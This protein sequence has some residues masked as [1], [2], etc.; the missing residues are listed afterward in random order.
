MFIPGSEDARAVAWSAD[1]VMLAAGC[2]GPLIRI[3]NVA[4]LHEPVT[5]RG[6]QGTVES[7]AWSPQAGS[8]VLASSDMNGDVRLWDM[9]A[10]SRSSRSLSGHR[11]LVR[12]LAWSP[13]G[14][15]LA[16]GS[17]DLTIRLWDPR[18]CE[19]EL[20]LGGS[21]LSDVER[22]KRKLK[23]ETE[24][25][26][27]SFHGASPGQDGHQDYITALA[28][29]GDG[30]TLASG[31]Y[32]MTVRLWRPD[33]GVSER[34]VLPFDE[35]IFALAWP[36]VPGMLT[37]G[38]EYGRISLWE[39]GEEAMAREFNC[40]HPEVSDIA[41]APGGTMMAIGSYVQ[42]AITLW[43]ATGTPRGSLAGNPGGVHALAWS[44]DGRLAS[45]GQ[46]GVRLWDGFT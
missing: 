25:Q 24:S 12:A 31:S 42:D 19:L 41:W 7:V 5:L 44:S 30:T 22:L 20:S 15:L 11:D 3:W 16:S 8:Y 13:D 33:E 18:S 36:P 39:P 17:D 26:V 38:E 29:S 27:I 28:W 6:H 1:G 34:A 14:S 37:V 40:G 45:A 21:P 2:G 46:G 32:D 23:I 43:T 4:R 35:Y 9:G 10:A